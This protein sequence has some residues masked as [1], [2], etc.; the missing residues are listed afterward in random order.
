MKHVIF[1]LILATLLYFGIEIAFGHSD[2]A[3]LNIGYA[4]LISV[5]VSVFFGGAILNWLLGG[6]VQRTFT[7]GAWLRSS[8]MTIVHS[9]E[10]LLGK[11]SKKKVSRKASKKKVLE[12]DFSSVGPTMQW[13]IVIAI[14]VVIT[15]FGGYAVTLSTLLAI[16]MVLVGFYVMSKRT[17][18]APFSQL[19]YNRWL[20]VYAGENIVGY[21]VN[22]ANVGVTKDGKIYP[23]KNNKYQRRLRSGPFGLIFRIFGMVYTGYI[24]G[25]HGV[26]GMEMTQTEL[27]YEQLGDGSVKAIVDKKMKTEPVYYV[28]PPLFIRRAI[29]YGGIP[30]EHGQNM[31]D[32]GLASTLMITDLRNVGTILADEGS[33]I[34]LKG[35]LESAL[36]PEVEDMTYDQVLEIRSEFLDKDKH[37][38]ELAVAGRVITMVNKA[39]VRYGYGLKIHDLDIP[40]IAPSDRE[41]GTA[42]RKKVLNEALAAAN[43]VKFQNEALEEETRGLVKAK[44]R[45][46]IIDASGDPTTALIAEGMEKLKTGV[47]F[48]WGNT[49]GVNVP[50]GQQSSKP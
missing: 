26:Q 50:V 24:P 40:A 39:S 3:L 42:K 19:P 29:S 49:T 1:W 16:A 10:K 33:F 7:S 47:T 6:Q 18:S 35:T 43:T 38:N 27:D 4:A 11:K 15:Y 22:V 46:A 23:D 2:P 41:F 44:V 21:Y 25:V 5:I 37:T 28:A 31:V 14:L 32:F 13:L 48:I 17:E 20:R 45:K 34:A 30:I 8:M 36:R 9:V 12:G